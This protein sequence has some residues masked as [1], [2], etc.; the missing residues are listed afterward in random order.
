MSKRSIRKTRHISMTP[1]LRGRKSELR[2]K[3][4]EISDAAAKAKVILK[5]RARRAGKRGGR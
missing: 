3:H 4:P 2:A 5:A 1:T